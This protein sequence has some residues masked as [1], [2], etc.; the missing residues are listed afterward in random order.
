[1]GVKFQALSCLF[2]LLNLVDMT[3]TIEEYGKLSAQLSCITRPRAVGTIV[4]SGAPSS[5]FV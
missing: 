3:E 2:V 4:S 5:D 1:M